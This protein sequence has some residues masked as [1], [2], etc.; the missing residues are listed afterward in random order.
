MVQLYYNVI[1]S[2]SFTEFLRI[3]LRTVMNQKKNHVRDASVG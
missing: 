3:Y 1:T 2:A